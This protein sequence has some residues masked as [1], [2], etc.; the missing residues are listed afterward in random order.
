MEAQ[1]QHYQDSGEVWKDVYELWKGGVD[2]N[3]ML[4]NES[5]LAKI[6]KESEEFQGLSALGKDKWM[7]DLA[8]TIKNAYK[9]ISEGRR[10]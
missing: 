3:G 10:A 9:Y 6:L 1:L 2:N 5:R 7:N 4:L 8:Q